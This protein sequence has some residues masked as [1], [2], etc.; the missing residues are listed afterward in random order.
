MRLRK[1]ELRNFKGVEAG[2]FEWEDII[3]LIGENNVGKSTVLQ[4]LEHFLSGNQIRDEALFF[5]ALT[6]EEHAIE[7]I[8]HFDH[9]TD[10]ESDASA[11]R[12]RMHE[13]GWILKK[14]FWRDAGAADA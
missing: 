10:A 7:L 13:G 11:I 3:V 9:V 5:N 14:R 12:G 8:G 2:S 1:F 6:D 4:A